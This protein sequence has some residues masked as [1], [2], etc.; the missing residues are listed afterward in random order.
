MAEQHGEVAEIIKNEATTEIWNGSESDYDGYS[1]SNS[2][3]TIL[4]Q[5]KS[6]FFFIIINTS[7]KDKFWE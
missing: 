2:V 7:K 4:S 3:R 6:V 1:S 5:L